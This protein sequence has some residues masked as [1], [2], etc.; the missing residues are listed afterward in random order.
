MS[1]AGQGGRAHRETRVEHLTTMASLDASWNDYT[2]PSVL[3]IGDL[4]TNAH[5]EPKGN[6]MPRPA[7]VPRGEL[8]G[9]VAGSLPLCP[10][11]AL[12]PPPS[13]GA[14]RDG[15]RRDEHDTRTGG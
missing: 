10:S 14:Q 2:P 9:G 8:P 12:Y 5:N 7:P 6:T 11:R 15:C 4:D 13:R 1:N 3:D